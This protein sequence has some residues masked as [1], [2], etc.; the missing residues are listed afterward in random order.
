[1]GLV[2]SSNYELF[3][4]TDTLSLADCKVACLNDPLCVHVT[5]KTNCHMYKKACTCGHNA[6]QHKYKLSRDTNGKQL[7]IHTSTDYHLS[8]CSD[9]CTD[10]ALCKEFTVKANGDCVL[11]DKCNSLTSTGSVVSDHYQRRDC[12]LVNTC[13]KDPNTISIPS[14]GWD[15]TQKDETPNRG[16]K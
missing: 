2:Y 7:A 12:E 13:A 4:R 11:Y 10:T 15:T 1:M 9:K 5:H 14:G 16:S 3:T 8:T 6:T